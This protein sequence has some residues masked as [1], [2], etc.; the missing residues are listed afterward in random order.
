MKQV[1]NIS[2]SQVMGGFQN[3]HMMASPN[4]VHGNVRHAASD[5]YLIMAAATA[6]ELSKAEV[7]PVHTESKVLSS[8]PIPLICS[9]CPKNT[10]FSDVS[11]LLTHIASKG[12]LS[13]M[14]KLDI[15]KYTDG[16]ARER[17]EEYQAWFD[18]H[19]IRELLQSRSENRIQKGSGGS[20]RGMSHA[21]STSVNLR[22][23]HGS[24][25]SRNN[26]RRST[27]T[28]GKRVSIP[29]CG[30]YSIVANLW[31]GLTR[32]SEQRVH[33]NS[34]AT[35]PLDSVKYEPEDDFD[36]VSDFTPSSHA[37]MQQP[38]RPNYGVQGWANLPLWNGGYNISGF[39]QDFGFTNNQHRLTN[40]EDMDNA[41]TSSK[42]EPSDIEDEI[43]TN[44]LPSEDTIDT[45]SH[46]QDSR[47]MP[48]H[49]DDEERERLHFRKYLKGD[50]S[51]IEGVGGFDAAPEEQRRQRNQKKDPSVLVH[52]EASSRAVRT[53]EQVTDLNFNHVRWR[54]VYDEPS[55]DGSEVS[56]VRYIAR[57]MAGTDAKNMKD[58]GDEPKPAKKP[59]RRSPKKTR[60]RAGR[61]RAVKAEDATSRESSLAPATRANRRGRTTRAARQLPSRSSTT[62]STNVLDSSQAST[63]TARPARS[64][65]ASV[66][67]TSSHNTLNQLPTGRVRIGNSVVDVFR[68]NGDTLPCE[69]WLTLSEMA[70]LLSCF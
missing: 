21:S 15:A 63:L 49:L 35:T 64:T 33:D 24:L 50:V 47:V 17:L 53:F 32:V 60:G 66:S 5:N 58:E 57:H 52:M 41:E 20:G 6:E 29:S 11:H 19:N 70:R 65:Q 55:V 37:H 9:I 46:E 26:T 28:R 10:Q 42:Y 45:T 23:G 40:E 36:S 48:E 2:F 13:N 56:C 31:D 34:D 16:N 1:A 12:H 44:L 61:P 27:G 67:S 38:W 39:Q 54:D 3:S 68:D 59:R 25:V 4:N 30:I 51:R 7:D 18:E 22:G 8:P 14:F 62:R 43:D 69:G